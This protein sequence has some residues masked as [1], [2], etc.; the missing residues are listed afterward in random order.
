[1]PLLSIINCRNDDVQIGQAII[2]EETTLAPWGKLGRRASR[3][4]V[5]PPPLS[6]SA[7]VSFLMLMQ[8]GETGQ[9]GKGDFY[10]PPLKKSSFTFT[11]LDEWAV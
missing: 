1:M 5:I 7:T 2:A 8:T 3:Y 9:Q 10:H 6:H 11:N 4:K